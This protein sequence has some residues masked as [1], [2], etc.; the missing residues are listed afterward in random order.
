MFCDHAIIKNELES[1]FGFES[2]Y[3]LFFF[4]NLISIERVLMLLP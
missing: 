1:K 4:V 2:D 3:S